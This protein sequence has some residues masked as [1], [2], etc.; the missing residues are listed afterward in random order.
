M[1]SQKEIADHLGLSV[2][3]VSRALRDRPDLSRETKDRVLTK[4]VELGYSRSIDPK[5]L[6]RKRVGVL[7]YEAEGTVL[8]ESEVYRKIFQTLQRECQR[9]KA[10][11][12]IET[13]RPGEA[14]LFLQNDTASALFILGRY[15]AADVAMFRGVPAL[16]LSSFAKGDPIP[17]I[18]ADN[19]GGMQEVTEHL[20]SLGHR[21]ILFLADDEA[22]TE[23]Y[24]QRATGYVSAM[25]ARGLEPVVRYARWGD[26]VPADVLEQIRR[27]TAVVCA[28]D[29][30]AHRL[31]R[32]LPGHGIETPRDCSIAA[33]DNLTR[34]GGHDITTY[35]PDWELMGKLAAELLL[36]RPQDIQ[37]RKLKI[38]VPG[39]LIVRGSTRPL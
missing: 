18:S 33:F 20:L 7:V 13:A 21:K 9:N 4:A 17:H 19:V 25:F 1:V 12:V 32:A 39:Q 36:F 6:V 2:M 38:T 29:T 28:N 22:G 27:H 10:E 14:P 15:E 8:L 26:V 34:G 3:T 5:A 24:R 11:T 23:L 37:D 16:A 30:L 35:A 31:L